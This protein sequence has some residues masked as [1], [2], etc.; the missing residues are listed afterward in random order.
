MPWWRNFPARFSFVLRVALSLSVIGVLPEVPPPANSFDL[1]YPGPQAET[2]AGLKLE[3]FSDRNQVHPGGRFLIYVMVTLE[4]GWHIYS[5]EPQDDPTLPTRIE[6]AA[7]EFSP[8]NGWT[9][10]DP[11]IVEDRILNRMVKVHSGRAEFQRLFTVPDG[12]KPGPYTLQGT[13]TYR[14]CD[15]KVCTR[16]RQIGFNTRID[17]VPDDRI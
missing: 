12:L 10:T 11:K 8:K 2:A 9:E 13:F 6:L 15:N 5:L 1:S 4:P 14:S 3:A 7:N 16:P 17:V